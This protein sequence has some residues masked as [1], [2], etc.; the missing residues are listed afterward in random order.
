M[1]GMQGDENFYPGVLFISFFPQIIQGPIPRYKQLFPQLFAGRLC[2]ADEFM[3]GIQLVIWGFFLKFML[4]NK[5]GIIVDSIF[6]SPMYFGYY[7]LVGG[8][9]Y[10]LQ[11][12]A[13]FEACV[14]I[15]QGVA[16]L[17]GI[18]LADN[19]RRPYFSTSVKEFWS[20]WHISLSTWLR[21][22]VYIPLGGNRHGILRKR[23]NLLLTF[24]VSG[25]WHGGSPKFLAWGIMHALYIILGEMCQK[26]RVQILAYCDIPR[27]SGFHIALARLGTGF[28]V[29]LAW[30]IFRAKDPSGGLR[31]IASIFTADNAWIFF[32]NSLYRLGLHQKEFD[33]L[34]LA[35]MVLA[36]VSALQER[37]VQLRAWF[38]KQNIILRWLVYLAAITCIWIFGTYGY[39]FNAND[40]I[41]GGF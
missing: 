13:D 27:Q 24:A 32:D 10:S 21:D 7:A 14:C 34:I 15:S 36:C 9:L 39:G 1:N 35:I 17:F 23:L 19:F 40:F 8:I 2:R 28:C 22:Y 6:N 4:A 5:A 30:I 12:Y 31:M 29:M 41:Y 3:Q 37:G 33:A 20:R 11:L 38:Q 25:L 18:K 26:W 16:Q